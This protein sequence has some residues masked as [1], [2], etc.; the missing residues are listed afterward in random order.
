MNDPITGASLLNYYPV[1]L[2]SEI[3]LVSG[4]DLSTAD[5]A[6]SDVVNF[7]LEQFRAPISYSR[8]HY[9]QELGHGLN[10]FEGL[11]S[12][13]PSDPLN[14]TFAAYRRSSGSSTVSTTSSLNPRT[15]M[16]WVRAQGHYQTKKTEAGLF[17]LYNSAFTG[18]DGGIQPRDSITDI[19]DENLAP[20]K[21]QTAIMHRTR[22]DLLGQLGFGLLSES[23]PTQ[24]SGYLTLSSR[25][26]FY[27]DSTFPPYVRE[28]SKGNRFGVTFLQPASLSLGT[29]STR[30]Q[31]RGDLQILDRTRTDTIAGLLLEKRYSVMGSDSIAIGG[32]FGISANGYIRTT[33]SQLTVGGDA[34]PNLALAAYGLEASA[35]ISKAFTITAQQSYSRDRSTLTPDPLATYELQN[36]GIFGTFSLSLGKSDSL[37]LTLGYLNRTEPEGIVLSPIGALDTLSRAYDTVYSPVF[38]STP[39]HSSGINGSFNLWV[40]KFRLSMQTEILPAISPVS[41]YTVVPA[42]RADLSSRITASAGIFYESEIAEGNLRISLGSRVRYYNHITPA[43]TYDP[44]SEYYVYQG[45]VKLNNNPYTDSRLTSPV[46]LIDILASALIDQRAYVN[47]S[48]LNILSKPYF[49]TQLYPRDGFVFRIDV[50]WAFLD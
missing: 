3:S 10:N 33:I 13:N 19:F 46:F 49:N 16:W 26:F 44:A 21:Y 27:R 48:F 32:A 20:V 6:S 25:R 15:D 42:L 7:R 37:S 2:A 24:L 31:V 28:L 40:D 36:I 9:T 1:E 29:F 14:L 41:S 35:R 30:A 22:L 8:I 39:I 4:G 47:F 17:I 23:D 12:I 11:F 38:S 5:H 43:L 18:S 45:L 50:S 34:K